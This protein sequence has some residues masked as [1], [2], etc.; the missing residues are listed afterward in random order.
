MIES[1][2]PNERI[3]RKSRTSFISI[4]TVHC[5]FRVNDMALEVTE[6]LG[7]AAAV[8]SIISISFNI[9]Q[10]RK[11]KNMESMFYAHLFQVY[12]HM[13]RIGEIS[14]ATKRE[15]NKSKK[16]N[17]NMVAMI[18]NIEQ[19]IGISN[20]VQQQSLNTSERYLRQPIWRQKQNKPDE[21]MLKKAKK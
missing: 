4:R 2:K 13:A 21:R 5:S 10:W 3:R 1:A 6:Y 17:Q 19:M 7:L 9:Y 20:S 16:P 11:Q 14:E 18:R 15:F 8:C 12:N